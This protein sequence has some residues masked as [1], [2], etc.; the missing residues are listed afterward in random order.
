MSYILFMCIMSSYIISNLFASWKAKY[1]QSTFIYIYISV[2]RLASALTWP[3]VRARGAGS[4]TG[5]QKHSKLPF[6]GIRDPEEMA[7]E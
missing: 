3:V 5:V 6:K 2:P 7:M 4:P 1:F